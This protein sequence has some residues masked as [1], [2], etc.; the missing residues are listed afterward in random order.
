MSESR[1]GAGDDALAKLGRRFREFVEF[2]SVWSSPLYTRLSLGV[3]D[4][5]AVLALAA[6]ATAR[7]VP[8]LLFA[9]VHY[10]LLRD[11]AQ[12]L[13]AFYPSLTPEPDTTGDPYPAFHA[14]CL[15][16]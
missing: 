12:P 1:Q 15:A 10:L 16:Q 3:A 6:E 2:E 7:P 9:A 11:P 14:F 13:A 8:N 5:P 4:D